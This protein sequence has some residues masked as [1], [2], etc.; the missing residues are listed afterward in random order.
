MRGMPSLV[1]SRSHRAHRVTRTMTTSAEEEAARK[2]YEDRV[3]NVSTGM[4]ASVWFFVFASAAMCGLLLMSF[5]GIGQVRA[6]RR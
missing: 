3:Y 2:E 4:V 1:L 6:Q 5:L